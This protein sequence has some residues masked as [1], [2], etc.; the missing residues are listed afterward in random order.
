MDEKKLREMV[1]QFRNLET[2]AKRVAAGHME[3]C[4]KA[5]AKAETA[6]AEAQAWSRAANILV[7]G[8]PGG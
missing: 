5:R 8:T 4:E 3:A 6:T 1:Q 2:E 7:S